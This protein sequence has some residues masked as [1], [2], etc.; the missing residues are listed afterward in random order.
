MGFM[1]YS[2]AKLEEKAMK[3]NMT[4]DEYCEY[5]VYKRRN[6]RRGQDHSIHRKEKTDA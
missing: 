2:T 3:R 6:R 1:G 5:L 4:L